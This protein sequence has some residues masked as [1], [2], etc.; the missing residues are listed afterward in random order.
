MRRIGLSI[1]L[2]RSNLEKNS[3]CPMERTGRAPQKKKFFCRREPT[4]GFDIPRCSGAR[5]RHRRCRIARWAALGF[6]QYASLFLG[7]LPLPQVPDSKVG[8]VGR[9]GK[10][11]MTEKEEDE[12]M[13]ARGQARKGVVQ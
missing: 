8:K 12:L 13:M 11:R 1:P 5:Y 2:L 9:G 3:P 6:D 7:A 10:G 4:L